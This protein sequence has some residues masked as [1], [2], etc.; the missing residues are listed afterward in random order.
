[1]TNQEIEQIISRNKFY[2]ITT[3]GGDK[4]VGLI[5]GPFKGKEDALLEGYE[6]DYLYITLI[7]SQQQILRLFSHNILKIVEFEV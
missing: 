7:N 2:T 1:M 3:D 6:Y 4:F 5:D